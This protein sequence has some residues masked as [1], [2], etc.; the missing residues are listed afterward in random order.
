[1]A[2]W[3]AR[4]TVALLAA[5]CKTFDATNFEGGV[6]G[7]SDAPEMLT[8]LIRERNPTV[9]AAERK[10]FLVRNMSIVLGG[11]VPESAWILP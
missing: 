6:T 5:L 2:T 7:V 11:S 10:D 1:M 3:K 9:L 8:L 4:V